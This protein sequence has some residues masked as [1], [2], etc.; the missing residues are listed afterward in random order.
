MASFGGGM[1]VLGEGPSG[2]PFTRVSRALWARE[3]L[4]K[5][6]PGPPAPGP[7]RE[8]GKSLEKVFRDLFRDFFQT[9]QTFSRL[10]PDSRGG[11]GAGGPGRLFF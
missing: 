9:L 7:P 6:L 3:T 1:G 5:S 10:F 4:K 2:D 8:S 11:P